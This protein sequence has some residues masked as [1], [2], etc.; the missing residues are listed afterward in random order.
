MVGPSYCVHKHRF[1]FACGELG[2]EPSGQGREWSEEAR[3]WSSINGRVTMDDMEAMRWLDE[4][5]GTW[6]VG[7]T[8]TACTVV[9]AVGAL[10]TVV[11]AG[12]L[13]ADLVRAALVQGVERIRSLLGDE[14]PGRRA[15][16]QP[17]ILSH[18]TR[19]EHV[20]PEP[21]WRTGTRPTAGL[22]GF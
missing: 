22:A 21:R 19:A 11:P 5:G 15:T 14:R 20:G 12:R 4:V 3:C 1:G 6:S 13:R 9:V 2:E 8:P 10:E 16:N 17:P 18:P 7:A